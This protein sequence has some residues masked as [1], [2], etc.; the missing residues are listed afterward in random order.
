MSKYIKVF[1]AGHRGMVG[2]SIV[3]QLKKNNNIEIIYRS[4][5]ELDLINQDQVRNFFSS[6]RPDQVY[7]AAAKV[8]GIYANNSYPA[9]FI[10]ENIMAATNVIHESWRSV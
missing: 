4:R 1:V 10:Y 7:F 2:S 6:E 9:E 8:G 3:R 5:E